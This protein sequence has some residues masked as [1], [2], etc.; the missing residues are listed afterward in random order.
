MMTDGWTPAAIPEWKPVRTRRCVRDLRPTADADF[1]GGGGCGDAGFQDAMGMRD[2]INTGAAE[3][4][5]LYAMAGDQRRR[6]R[7]FRRMRGMPSR[8]MYLQARADDIRG[9]GAAALAG[10]E[11]G[12]E[13]GR[14]AA[15]WKISSPRA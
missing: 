15:G 5:M 4:V 8:S 12:G 14:S 9:S 3:F 1:G 2:A 7:K 6:L 10:K 11:G 13:R